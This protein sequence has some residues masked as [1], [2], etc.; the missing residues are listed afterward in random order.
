VS[1]DQTSA[2]AA[3]EEA[4]KLIT[5]PVAVIGAARGE[6][7]G[8]MTA[9]WLTRVSYDPP[10]LMVAVGRDRHTHG[11]LE[12]AQE[13]TVSI[14]AED[15]TEVARLF[16]LHSRRERDKWDETEHVLMGNGIPALAHCSAR[17]LCHITDRYPLG[18]HT[19]F[20]G[21]V[22]AAEVVAG[23]PPLPLRGS[24]YVT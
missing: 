14:L 6:E 1:S 16:G 8:G 23:A 20:V 18:D 13:Y 21:E 10:L 11:M 9:A 2:A 12:A 3:R 5:S 4:L 15:Q 19:G 22:I 24:D 17:L 7:L